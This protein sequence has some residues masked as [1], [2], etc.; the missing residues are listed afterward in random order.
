MTTYIATISFKDKKL[1]EV[2]FDSDEAITT[3]LN[4][5]QK[6]LENNKEHWI[7]ISDFFICKDEILWINLNYD[8]QVKKAQ[9]KKQGEKT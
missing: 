5:L 3:V 9:E 6:D 8:K 1:F 7:S 4:V 2:K